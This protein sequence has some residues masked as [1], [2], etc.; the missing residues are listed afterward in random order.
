MYTSVGRKILDIVAGEFPSL[1]LST[2]DPDAPLHEWFDMDSIQLVALMAKIE[3][4]LEIEIPLS[5]LESETLNEFFAIIE[6]QVE[7]VT[8]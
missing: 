7:V 1:H 3:E 5:A 6:K 4:N 8:R 2:I